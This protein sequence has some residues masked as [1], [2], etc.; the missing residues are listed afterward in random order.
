MRTSQHG[1]W[2]ILPG[3]C[4]ICYPFPFVTK[5]IPHYLQNSENSKCL[6]GEFAR[7]FGS[8]LALSKMTNLDSSKL[9]EFADNTLKFNED[10]SKFIQMGRKHSGKRRNCSLRAI[11]TFPTVFS[12][13]LYCRHIKTMACLGKG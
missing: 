10:G 3:L 2:N 4:Q 1:C 9:T 11:S 12:K 6:K 13:D 8:Y 7:K 5:S